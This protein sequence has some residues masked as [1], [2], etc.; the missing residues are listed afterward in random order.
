MEIEILK[1]LRDNPSYEGFDNEPLSLE[2]IATLELDYNEGNSFPRALRELLYLAG[3]YCLVYDYGV[4]DTMQ[5]IQ[6]AGR[7]WL[8]ERGLE[9]LRPFFILDVYNG[10]DQFLFVYLDEHTNDPLLYEAYLDTDMHDE[11]PF[12]SSLER[13][14]A[15][16]T[17]AR[18]D[19]LLIGENP[20]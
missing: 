18:L 5:E 19:R 2:E 14:L 12:L 11:N 9:I 16:F 15:E 17:D 20:F 4:Y 7:E 3:R 6:E 8:D 13:T 10:G 1:K